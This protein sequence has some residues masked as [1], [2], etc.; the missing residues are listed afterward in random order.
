ME[1]GEFQ[2][3]Y[4]N[5]NYNIILTESNKQEVRVEADKEL[6]DLTHLW[7]DNG[8]LHVD[9]KI[10]EEDGKSV[11]AKIDKIKINSKRDIYIK[12]P[13]IRSIVVNGDGSVA[14]ENSINADK[15]D[16]VM[17]GNGKVDMNLKSE[18]VNVEIYSEGAVS[19]SG[20]C[21]FLNAEVSGKGTFNG[22]NFEAKNGKITVRG[23]SLAETNLTDN[24]DA[25]VYGMGTIKHKGDTKT[26][27]SYIYGQGNVE[28]AY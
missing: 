10:E 15:I 2:S 4:L 5:S 17:N 3:I 12:V 20:Y 13:S 11:W 28:R 9:V 7:V 1:L 24:I 27:K 23:S 6:W 25:Y 26:V 14:V 8:I 22:F 21:N 16:I 18:N 19:L